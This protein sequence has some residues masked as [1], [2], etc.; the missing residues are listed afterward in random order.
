MKL[1]GIMIQSRALSLAVGD[2]CA[3]R[4][5]RNLLSE[6]TTGPGGAIVDYGVVAVQ[7]DGE[8][9]AYNGQD[10]YRFILGQHVVVS[11][12]RAEEL[13]EELTR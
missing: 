11:R 12:E 8:A 2:A 1:T 4:H 7:K 13:L 6:A 9:V 5:L 3:T 10:F